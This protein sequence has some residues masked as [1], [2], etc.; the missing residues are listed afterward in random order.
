MVGVRVQVGQH[1]VAG[2]EQRVVRR[3]REV[4]VAGHV[5]RGDQVE[6]VVVGVPVSA[7]PVGLL[8]ALDDPARLGQGLHGGQAGGAGADHAVASHHSSIGM[9]VLIIG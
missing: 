8:K 1:L 6:R 3:H 4:V 2:G 7:D 5:A 9:L